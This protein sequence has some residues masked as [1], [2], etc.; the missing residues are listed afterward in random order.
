MLSRL[1]GPIPFS[2]SQTTTAKQSTFDVTGTSTV[3]TV[4][5][6]AVV[7]LGVTINDTTVK[8]TQDKANTVISNVTSSLG[9][10][11]IDKKDIKTENYSLYPTYDYQAGGQRITGYNVNASL[12]VSVTDFAIL[13]QAI[14]AAT[15]AGANQVGGVSFTLSDDKKK[16]VEDDAR[17]QAIDDAKTKANTL[18]GLAGMKLGKIVNIFEQPTNGGYPMP[19]MYKGGAADARTSAEQVPTTTEPGTTTLNYSVTLSYETL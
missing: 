16:S 15:A 2:I 12:S 4:P 14:D 6:K 7:N 17:K 18:A 3:S 5:D 8:A 13:N 1:V 10:L 19:M 9:K 11:G